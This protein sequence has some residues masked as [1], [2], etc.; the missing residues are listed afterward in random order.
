MRK[1]LLLAF[2]ISMAVSTMML[3]EIYW[4]NAGRYTTQTLATEE[5]IFV[6]SH[7]CTVDGKPSQEFEFETRSGKRVGAILEI[8]DEMAKA[9]IGNTGRNHVLVSY[10]TVTLHRRDG[11]V[12]YRY[13]N[14]LSWKSLEYGEYTAW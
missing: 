10:E 12:I 11:K 9:G 13:Q 7:N 8:A 14:L 6:S 3:T 2:L 1:T 4:Q 5:A